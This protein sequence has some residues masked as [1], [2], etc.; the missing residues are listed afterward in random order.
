[1]P[2]LQGTV[3][4][5]RRGQE[6]AS[7]TAL[8]QTN[9]ASTPLVTRR[10]FEVSQSADQHL[11]ISGPTRFRLPLRFL[12]GGRLTGTSGAHTLTGF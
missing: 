7:N 6:G 8:R 4:P 10:L 11:S 2:H 1:M 3:Q 12:M 9:Q 5:A